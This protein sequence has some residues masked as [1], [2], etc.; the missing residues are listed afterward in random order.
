MSHDLSV[1]SSKQ[2]SIHQLIHSKLYDES[3]FGL[4][5]CFI[6]LI[7]NYLQFVE[8]ALSDAP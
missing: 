4:R 3:E 6:V 7:R 1:S 2:C 5:L 8:V